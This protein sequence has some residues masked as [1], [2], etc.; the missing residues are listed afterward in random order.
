MI[1]H[2]KKGNARTTKGPLVNHFPL[3]VSLTLLSSCALGPVRRVTVS[4]LQPYKEIRTVG[5]EPSANTPPADQDLER[6]LLFGVANGIQKGGGGLSSSNPG[7]FRL[8]LSLLE[9]SAGV[10][11]GNPSVLGDAATFL[12]VSSSV[13]NSG[14]LAFAAYLVAPSEELTLGY[15]RWEGTGNPSTLAARA[16]TELGEALAK[17]MELRRNERFERRVLDDRFVLT[18]TAQTL[19]PGAFVLSN[20]EALLFRAAIGIHR[21]V[22]LN[23]WLGGFGVPFGGGFVLPAIHLIGA[24]GG[25]GIALVGAV[26]VGLKFRI[27][28]EG[29]YVP[30]LAV[31]YDMTNCFGAIFGAG[32]LVL[33]GKGGGAIAAAAGLATANVQLNVFNATVA[34]HFG[35]VQVTAGAYVIDNHHWLPQQ[36]VITTGVAAV[37]NGVVG[38]ASNDSTPIP[39]IPTQVQPYAAAEWVLGPHSALL[40]EFLPR[41][42]FEETMVTTGAR[43]QL[44]WTEP[45]GP[46]ARD[47]IR[48]RIDLAGIWVYLPKSNRSGPLVAPLPWL[49]LGVAFN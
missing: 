7:G 48:F 40:F 2:A 16:G 38:A 4:P 41:L 25:G 33:G 12:G 37:S 31:S 43:W 24:G 1:D 42:P 8:R 26:D 21:R 45:A 46:I 29:E 9:A 35:P 17:Q 14:R 6:A 36:A 30:G 44:G 22:Q 18:P 34:K 23:F 15:A 19:E 11:S 13:P 32:A 28:D 47:R 3:V 20:D 39:R 27:L 5:I 10:P 49:G